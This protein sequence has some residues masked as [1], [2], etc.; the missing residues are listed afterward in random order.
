M[1]TISSRWGSKVTG[2]RLHL[3]FETRSAC[4]LKTAGAYRYA[5]D[6]TTQVTDLAWSFGDEKPRHWM[7]GTPFP[8]RVAEH[9]AAGGEVVC[10]NAAFERR[11]WNHVLRRQV[12]GLPE[13]AIEQQNC[14]LARA[15]AMSY[16][17]DLDTLSKALGSPHKK[18]MEG[19]ALMLR[20][21]KPSRTTGEF[22][23]PTPEQRVRRALYN[24]R[25]V[26]AESFVDAVLPP[27]PARELA[28]WVADQKIN[29]RGIPIDIEEVKAASALAK[30][31]QRD[32]DKEMRQL[33]K[34]FV[35]RVTEAGKLVEWLRGRGLDA[36]SAA[37]T[38]LD[39]LDI[40][41]FPDAKR[42]IELRTGGAKSSLAKFDKMLACVCPDE[43]LRDQYAYHKAGTGRWAARIVQVQNFKR[44][45]MEK[46]RG[47]FEA[48]FEALHTFGC[49]SDQAY[50]YIELATGEPVL[51]LLARSMRQF[52]KAPKGRILYGADFSNV[53][54]RF[55]AWMAGQEDTL[56][57]F[58]D[59]DAGHGPDMYK[60]TYATSFG[61]HPSEV[62]KAQRQLGKIQF[63]LLGYGG[64]VRAILKGLRSNK[65]RPADIVPTVR[66]ATEAKIWADFENLYHPARDK[67]ELSLDCWVAIKVLI[68]N[69]R[70][71]NDRIAKSWHHLHNAAVT[72]VN[73]PRFPI[74]AE[75]Y[76]GVT[77][78]H[79]DGML[80]CK[81]PSGR[82]MVYAQPSIVIENQ[83]SLV[84]E[85]GTVEDADTYLPEDIKALV[86]LGLAQLVERKPRPQ[87]R[88][89]GKVGG[90][91]MPK[92][93]YGGLQCE[94]VCQ[95]GCR[96]FQADAILDLE[97]RGYPV[98][99]H[100]HD[101]IVSEVDER[102][103]SEQEFGE[104]MATPRVWAPGM[105]LAVKTWSGQ[106]YGD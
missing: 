64:G 31:A 23:D 74:E 88:F 32:L 96:D 24:I 70:M 67:C 80:W 103:G 3:D 46:D 82:M 104:I 18:D 34:G 8:R 2:E 11:I 36:T 43:R 68:R 97:A 55:N 72:A 85:D 26:E 49:R 19:N 84:W 22:V 16:P 51:D 71:Q 101:D 60:V 41:T 48:V 42:V 78:L 81:L 75:D 69:F 50:A 58:R 95:A 94:N 52:I 30:L 25:D 89:F 53:E 17:D 106:R 13:M 56:Q 45:D 63:L 102:A 47:N 86:D 29:D 66:A 93:L 37:E 14:T 59:Y 92:R 12:P 6:K 57:A 77:Y 76:K 15:L 10:H 100:T 38:E 98:V 5:I 39:Q 33:T 44:L 79:Q 27:L 40:S 9:V 73:N 20:F 54:G 62:T 87:V 83:D 99:M 91:W 21:C 4:E 35:Q 61:C 7:P 28:I 65:L 1:R 90:A 105:P